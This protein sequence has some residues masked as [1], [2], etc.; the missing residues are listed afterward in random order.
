MTHYIILEVC[1]DGIW[2]LS[3]DL[4]LIVARFGGKADLG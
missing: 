4:V 1:W 2:T 3:Y